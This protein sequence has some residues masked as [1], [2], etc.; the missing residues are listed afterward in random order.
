MC[1]QFVFNIYIYHKRTALEKY[2]TTQYYCFKHEHGGLL[3]KMLEIV[4]YD[5]KY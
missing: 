1:G 3:Q 2:F 5:L 4:F